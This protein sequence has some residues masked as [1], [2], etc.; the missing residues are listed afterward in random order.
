M[1]EITDIDVF[2][3]FGHNYNVITWVIAPTT[4]IIDNFKLEVQR[5]YSLEDT[6]VTIGEG[7]SD[8][9]TFTDSDVYLNDRFR[10][11]Y[12]RM[13]VTDLTTSETLDTDPSYSSYEWNSISTEIARRENLLLETYINRP[14]KFLVR[15]TEG[16]YCNCFDPIK[17]RVKTSYCS[18]CYGTG[19]KGG[20]YNPIDGYIGA[21]PKTEA[22]RIV[23]GLELSSTDPVFWT[24][25]SLK[26]SP[27]DIIIDTKSNE[28]FRVVR[29][30]TTTME[31]YPLKQTLICH[32]IK[33]SDI[34]YSIPI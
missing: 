7:T 20:F 11:Y 22:I 9:V 3:D 34:E 26:L 14:V 31:G 6:F 24:S 17:R 1:L 4:Q 32:Q 25:N 12:Y 30:E 29:I 33:L 15:K 18:D 2:P 27:D 8:T 5:A 28:R 19:F 16:E 10:K 23:I 13:H 21:V